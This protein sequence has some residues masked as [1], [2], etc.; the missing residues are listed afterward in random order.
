MT[1]NGND[2]DMTAAIP[3]V[4]E[5]SNDP[6]MTNDSAAEMSHA[7]TASCPSASARSQLPL[8]ET[9]GPFQKTASNQ[10]PLHNNKD[11]SVEHPTLTAHSSIDE[12]QQNKPHQHSVAGQGM[13]NPTM[14]YSITQGR[15]IDGSHAQLDIDHPTR[16]QLLEELNR[17]KIDLRE[18]ERYLNKLQTQYRTNLSTKDQQIQSL[19]EQVQTILTRK[20]QE[21]KD[22]ADGSRADIIQKNRD[23]DA[24]RQ[25]WKQT[26]R[27][28]GKYQTQEKVVDQVTDPEMIQKAR[29]L[30]YNV[31]NLAYQHFG[32]ELN[33]GKSV[34]DSWQCLQK[35]LRTPTDYFE[36]CMSSPVKRP[37]LVGAFLWE[38]LVNEIFENFWWCGKGVNHD[39]KNLTDVLSERSHLASSMNDT[40]TFD[41]NPAEAIC[42][43]TGPRQNADIRC[44]KPTLAP[45]WWMRWNLTERKGS[46]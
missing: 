34:Q 32:G 1:N 25:M 2:K 15:Q 3:A 23:L 39:M 8:H 18:K 4:R 36:A 12:R 28:L 46:V 6:A 43:P 7:P 27:E 40:N 26:A 13:N 5:C 37:M 16:E 24:V 33:T 22:L 38:F 14:A 31:R 21:L 42:W 45:S 10:L 11:R 35:Q 20:D 41:Q 44:G 19:H 17:T 29:Q 9:D 30:Q